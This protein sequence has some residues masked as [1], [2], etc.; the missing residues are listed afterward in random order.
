[1]LL[2]TRP[3]GPLLA[4]VLPCLASPLAAQ[5][6]DP[7]NSEPEPAGPTI[8][9]TGAL[10]SRSLQSLDTPGLGLA[11]DADQIAAV[12]AINTEDVIRYAPGL[13][14]RKRYIGDANATLSLRNMHT[15]QTPRALVSVD[16]FVIANFLGASFDTA[17]KWGVLAPGDIAR[18]E[19]VYGPSSARYSGHALGGVLRLE[20]EPVSRT[21]VSLGAQ[22]FFQSYRYYETDEDLF[23]YAL[24][25]RAD[26]ALGSGGISFAWRHFENEGQPQQWRTVAPGTPYA[27]Q[28]TI[29]DALGFP[30]RIAAQDSVVDAREDQFRLRANQELGGDW[31]LRALAALLLDRDGTSEPKSFLTDGDG[32]PTFV[33]IAGVTLGRSRSAELLA[34]LGLKGHLGDWSLDLAVSRFETLDDRSRQSDPADL[35]TGLIPQ[36][37]IVTDENARW[38]TIELTVERAIGP[39][40]LALGAS[41]AGYA[42]RSRTAPVSDWRT[43]APGP[44]RNA[45]GGKSELIG[46]FVEDAISLTPALEATLGLRYERWRAADGFL[47]NAGAR[48]DYRGRTDAAWSPKV[49]LAWRV[50]DTSELSASLAW[51]TRFPTIGELYQASLIAY[52]PNVGEI[53]LGGFDPDLAPERGFDMQ[54]TA[55]QR[56]GT[57]DLTLSG[58]RQNVRDTLFG[59]TILVAGPGE[60]PVSQSL[61]TNIGAVETWGVDFIVAAEDVVIEG[62]SF[63]GNISWIDARIEGNPLNPALEGNR[64]PRVPE[65]RA[66]AS[67]RYAVSDAFELAASVRHQSTPERNLENSASSRCD[68]FFCVSSFAFVDLKASVDFGPFALDLGVDNLLGE[69]AF[70]FHPYP[71]RTFVA[72]LR[73]TGGRP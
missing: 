69:R 18:A 17:P 22:S 8:V 12:N 62:L 43:A 15:T 25:A 48:V 16:G 40:R 39:H 71:G 26:L 72:G 47:Q 5:S 41:Y 44:V 70:V 29:D 54:V 10:E 23:G 11:V 42:G 7:G 53:D 35:A 58:Y 36:G 1:M 55:R 64:F 9:V 20:T 34:G 73:W 50:S 27:A 46:L 31:E 13:V 49:A 60:V 30:L 59:Q 57:I 33:G 14:V 2:P 52:G 28:A 19:I 21:A 32:Q 4:A 65:W 56:L 63:D 66:N 24:D 51:A 38:T 37:G 61:I 68:T 6:T 67:L 45:S 3:C